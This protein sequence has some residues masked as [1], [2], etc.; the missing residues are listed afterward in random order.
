MKTLFTVTFLVAG[1]AFFAA[2]KGF[3]LTHYLSLP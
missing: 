1:A 2:A 3:K